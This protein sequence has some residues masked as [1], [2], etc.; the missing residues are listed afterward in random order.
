MTTLEAAEAFGR[1]TEREALRFIAEHDADAIEAQAE[2][3]SDWLD[4]VRLCVWL[5]Y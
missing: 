5:G 4:A 2:L 3:G 1:M